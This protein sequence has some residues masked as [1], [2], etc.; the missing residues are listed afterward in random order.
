MCFKNQKRS[1]NESKAI[2]TLGNYKWFTKNQ[3]AK[4]SE[5]QSLKE[6]I[7]STAGT[8]ALRGFD[9]EGKLVAY[10][11]NITEGEGYELVC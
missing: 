2:H 6:S 9:H 11:F 10:Y 8:L 3:K 4:Y 7:Q 5:Q 1:T